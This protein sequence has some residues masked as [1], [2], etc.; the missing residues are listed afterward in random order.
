MKKLRVLR[1]RVRGTREDFVKSTV[2]CVIC[3]LRSSVF[4][5]L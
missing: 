5:P 2:K 3:H 1:M 4:C